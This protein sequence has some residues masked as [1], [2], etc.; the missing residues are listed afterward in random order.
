M[1][2]GKP[3]GPRKEKPRTGGKP[4]TCRRDGRAGTG[5]RGV[6]GGGAALPRC[7]RCRRPHRTC[8]IPAARASYPKKRLR[9]GSPARGRP[10]QPPPGR[11][12]GTG[13]GRAAPG[14][15]GGRGAGRGRRPGMGTGDRARSARHRPGA[16]PSPDPSVSVNSPPAPCW[17]RAPRTPPPP[18]GCLGP[19]RAPRGHSSELPQGRAAGPPLSRGFLG[20]TGRKPAR[21]QP[22]SCWGRSNLEQRAGLGGGWGGQLGPV[23]LLAPLPSCGSGWSEPPGATWVTN[24]ARP[25]PL[26]APSP[27][28]CPSQGQASTWKSPCPLELS[29][30]RPAPRG[31]F[32]WVLLVPQE[33][34]ATLRTLPQPAPRDERSHRRPIRP[35]PGVWAQTLGSGVRLGVPS[36]SGGMRGKGAAAQRGTHAGLCP[37]CP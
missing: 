30:R 35:L 8:P 23:L 5:G 4:R 31:G 17:P 13:R 36:Q 10:V 20:L 12:T 6:C 32:P 24:P 22:G 28:P 1:P 29:P 11:G 25:L 26:P 21:T 18:A 15:A 14:H 3:R 9:T 19:P 34:G 27:F 2:R 7:C 16:G 37:T 33:S